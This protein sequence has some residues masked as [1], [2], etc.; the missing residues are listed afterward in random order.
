[1]RIGVAGPELSSTV[2]RPLM[3]ELKPSDVIPTDIPCVACGFSLEGLRKPRVV[4]RVREADPQLHAPKSPLFSPRQVVGPRDPIHSDRWRVC[5][6]RTVVLRVG[7]ESAPPTAGLSRHFLVGLQRCRTWRLHLT[8][9]AAFLARPFWCDD[10][11]HFRRPG[12]GGLTTRC[13][14]RAARRATDSI[15]RTYNVCVVGSAS[16]ARS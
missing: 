2:R 11:F 4:P 12:I 15:S 14:R 16:P 9:R 1:M 7:A 13:S 5:E 6:S 10:S 3:D 8:L